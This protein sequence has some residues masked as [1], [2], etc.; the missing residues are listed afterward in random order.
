MSD[1]F[2]SN[3]YAGGH[4]SSEEPGVYR[5]ASA[6]SGAPKTIDIM[7]IMFACGLLLCGMCMG[8]QILGQSLLGPMMAA[9]Q[10]QFE[11]E[12]KRAREQQIAELEERLDTAETEQQEQEIQR[13]IDQLKQMP[14]PKM[15]DMTKLWGMNDPRIF[16]YYAGDVAT[17]MVL[18]VLLL[19]SGIGLLSYRQWARKLAIWVAGLKILRLGVLC[20]VGVVVVAPAMAKNFTAFMEEMEKQMEQA[21]PQ[22]PP[23]GPP[24]QD[25]EQVGEAMG[26][27]FAGWSLGMLVLGSIYPVI[28]LVVLQRDDVRRACQPPE[29][30]AA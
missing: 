10:P 16:G 4:Y 25:M 17:G 18:N 8:L 13:E 27:F 12:M 24:Q 2:H 21:P 30:S 5:T 11:A 9:Q 3:P 28:V 1:D 20:V 26:T 19:V 29:P 7:N 14:L 22:A 6:E 15:P 23:P